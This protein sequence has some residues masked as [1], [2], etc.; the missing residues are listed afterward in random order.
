M[1]DQDGNGNGILRHYGVTF[2]QRWRLA[3]NQ[4]K[5][6]TGIGRPMTHFGIISDLQHE[7][8]FLRTEFHAI[9]NLIRILGIE[10]R[11]GL[12]KENT[13][14]ES[15]HEGGNKTH[16]SFSACLLL[17]KGREVIREK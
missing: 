4:R 14:D 2:S 9:S 16:K 6:K 3:I 17:L 13:A 11:R 10:R 15:I 7:L 12:D 1:L 5:T 8:T